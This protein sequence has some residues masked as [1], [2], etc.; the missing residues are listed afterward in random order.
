MRE[1]SLPYKFEPRE[2]QTPVFEAFD[3]GI[4]RFCMVWHR[5]A[6]KDKLCWQVMIRAMVTN[7][8]NYF[9]FF[10][11]YAQARKAAWEQ[12]DKAGFKFLDHLPRVMR[13]RVLDKE[14]FIE[15]KPQYGGSTVRFIGADR[16]DAIVGTNPKGIVFSEFS[17]MNPNAWELFRPV[18]LE[19]EGW[20][21]FNGTPRGRNHFY[22][23]R[24]SPTPTGFSRRS[25]SSTRGR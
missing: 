22:S 5:R 13:E 17:L 23:M 24:V 16:I 9:Y 7:P 18:L 14:M 25:R 12:V 11:T 19:N 10:P 6:G 21:I 1:I 4:R 2:Y 15:M 20:A 8:G 3:N